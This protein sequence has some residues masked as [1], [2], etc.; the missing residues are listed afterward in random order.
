MTEIF[1][2]SL[3]AQKFN[4]AT[5][6]V[7]EEHCAKVIAALRVLPLPGV[8]PVG[9]ELAVHLRVGLHGRAEG[10]PRGDAGGDEGEQSSDPSAAATLATAIDD[11]SKMYLRR[12]SRM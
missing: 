8:K 7:N 3:D 12:R 6:W 10:P 5:R 4:Q 2:S 11:V 9:A 1:G